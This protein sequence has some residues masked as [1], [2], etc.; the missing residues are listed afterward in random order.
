MDEELAPKHV[1]TLILRVDYAYQYE[2]RPELAEEDG[3][4]KSQV[5]QIVAAATRKNV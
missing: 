2:S 4:G 1:N 5:K 3:L